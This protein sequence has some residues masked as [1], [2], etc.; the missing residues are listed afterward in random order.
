LES[1]RKAANAL[2]KSVRALLMVNAALCRMPGYGESELLGRTVMEITH[3]DDL[4]REAAL[5][6]P[7]LRGERDSIEVEKRY[8]HRDGSPV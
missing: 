6:E 5:R 1:A 2:A 3:P 7:V 8:L 4:A